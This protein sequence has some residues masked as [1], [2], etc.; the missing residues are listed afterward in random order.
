M[1]DPDQ[2]SGRV[3]SRWD[4]VFGVDFNTGADPYAVLSS[5]GRIRW[6]GLRSAGPRRGYVAVWTVIGFL[7]LTL[8]LLFRAGARGALGATAVSIGAGVVF[9]AVGLYQFTS[10]K[11]V[12]LRAYRTPLSF[13]MTR[14][15]TLLHESSA[16]SA[17]DQTT[18]LYEHRSGRP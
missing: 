3:H 5:A 1:K 2:P 11:S 8:F 13:I 14:C 17:E 16:R 9:A 10:W 12:C 15:L 4:E 18:A 6:A 7:P